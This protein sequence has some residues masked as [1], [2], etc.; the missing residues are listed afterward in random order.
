M[1]LTIGYI[2]IA[3][4]PAGFIYYAGLIPGMCMLLISFASNQSVGYGD[5]LTILMLGLLVGFKL[6]VGILCLSLFLISIYSI[7]LLIIKKANRKTTIPYIPFLLAA[8]GIIL[9]SE[10]I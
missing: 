5:G 1:I 4:K 6:C 3:V 9:W 7:V 10:L 8:G 2:L